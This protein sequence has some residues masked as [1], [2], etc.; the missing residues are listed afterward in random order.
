MEQLDLADW[1]A[2]SDSFPKIPLTGT[3]WRIVENQGRVETNALVDD[4][5]EQEVLEELLEGSKPHF[6]LRPHYL[7][8]TP[9]RYPPLKWGSRFGKRME[10]SLFYGSYRIETVLAECAFYRFLF[11]QGMSYLPGDIKIITQHTVFSARFAANPG[12]ALFK[13]PFEA[14]QHELTD[15]SSYHA[16]QALGQVLR[17]KG[18][19][20]FSFTSARCPNQGKNIGLFEKTALISQSPDRQELYLCETRAEQVTFKGHIGIRGF[21][22]THF[23]QGRDFPTPA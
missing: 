16:T 2:L 9:F 11:L 21:E 10:K 5:A 12:I 6:D 23:Q 14:Y 8:T 1:Q 22:K 13:F 3:L 19:L 18:Y 17:E 4:L 20:G 7:L 15:Q